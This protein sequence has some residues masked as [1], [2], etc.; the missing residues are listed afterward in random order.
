MK[1][2]QNIEYWDRYKDAHK[3]ATLMCQEIKKAKSSGIV[4]PKTLTIRHV[5]GTANLNRLTHPIYYG[6]N[7][8]TASKYVDLGKSGES[9]EKRG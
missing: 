6:M 3:H 2:V 7:N 4:T 9:P 5:V 8:A 1:N